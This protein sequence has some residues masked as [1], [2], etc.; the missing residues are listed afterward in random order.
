MWHNIC[1]IG[2]VLCAIKLVIAYRTPEV[3]TDILEDFPDNINI[4]P[5]V[6]IGKKY[7]YFGESKVSWF[8][9][10]RI[11][12]YMGSDLA[13]YETAQEL[14]ELSNYLLA[15]YS[16]NFNTWLSASDVD[17]E[18]LWIWYSTG[19]VM[20]YGDWFE[21]QPDNFMGIEHCAQLFSL[22]GKYRMNDE[23]CKSRRNYICQANKPETVAV[24]VGM[25]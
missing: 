14:T 8:N 13:S 4:R 16:K 23:D 5:F 1:K 3:A 15:R 6:K 19:E 24:S 25:F 9:A 17:S 22:S 12:R 11:C 10:L 2:L 7:Y 18:G 21:G 20:A